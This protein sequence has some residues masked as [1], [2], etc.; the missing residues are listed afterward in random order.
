MAISGMEKGLVVR[1]LDPPL[2]RTLAVIQHHN[3]PEEKALTIVREA[4]LGLRTQ[5]GGRNARPPLSLRK[6]R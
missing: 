4:I 3:K 5:L 2:N 1:P 6:K